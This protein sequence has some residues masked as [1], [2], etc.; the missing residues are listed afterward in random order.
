MKLNRIIDLNWT[1]RVLTIGL[2]VLML[3]HGIDKVINGIDFIIPL[4][5]AYNVPYAEYIAYGVYVGEVFAP[6]LL[7][8][9]YYIKVAGAIIVFNMLV[10]LFLVHQEE[11]LTLTEYGSWSIETPILYLI[12]GLALLLSNEPHR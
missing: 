7:I 6:L 12:I 5:E 3:F 9:G 11:I 1:F 10:A 4:L 8:S 2:G